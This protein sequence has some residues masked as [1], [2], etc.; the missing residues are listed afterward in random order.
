[1]NNNFYNQIKK[2]ICLIYSSHHTSKAK[3]YLV[4][5]QY[6]RLYQKLSFY[7]IK[8]LI[9]KDYLNVSNTSISSSIETDLRTQKH[10]IKFLIFE[11]DIYY[12][13]KF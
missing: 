4:I 10:D 11:N 7:Y 3:E 12:H 9:Y 6:Y 1:M 8:H 2:Y 13:T 5:R